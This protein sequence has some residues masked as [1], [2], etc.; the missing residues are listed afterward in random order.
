MT[1]ITVKEIS[2]D[3]YEPLSIDAQALFTQAP[4][5]GD[6]QRGLNKKVF[7]FGFYDNDTPIGFAQ[8]VECHLIK[9]KKYY[10]AP[11]GPTLKP[12]YAHAAVFKVIKKELKDFFRNKNAA[13]V[14]LDFM[15]ALNKKSILQ[16]RKVFMPGHYSSV[17]GACFQ[18][19]R[20]W[21]LPI[22]DTEENILKAMHQKTRYNIR[23]AERK[24]VSVE[25]VTKNLS[26]YL[27]DF[28]TVQSITAK[29]NGFELHEKEY[30]ASVLASVD[31]ENAE[32]KV[33]RGY[34]AIARFQGEI[35]T[36][37]FVINYGDIAM[38]AFGGS[39]NEH[40]NLMP[41]YSAHWEGARFAK[42]I[43][44]K[45]YNFG[46]YFDENGPKVKPATLKKRSGFSIF[47][48]K[49]GGFVLEHSPFFDIVINPLWYTLYIINKFFRH[50]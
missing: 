11:Y 42:S 20:E 3:L 30:Y 50:V 47:K 45:Y 40:R 8:F 9:N 38:F 28:Y 21:F 32:K 13:F 34:L 27:E 35:L 33:V 26:Q 37:N 41:S 24:G 18:P 48:R 14:R 19:R 15:P 29:R 7:L 25:I 22:E 12:Q 31:K 10:I 4:F 16:A 1:H 17:H 39:T 46:G 36:V 5:Y 44:L 2:A 23:L 49:F 6:W 43:G